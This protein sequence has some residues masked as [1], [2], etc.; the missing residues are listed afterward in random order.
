MPTRNSPTGGVSVTPRPLF[1]YRRQFL[2]TDDEL[3][4]GRLL[5]CP[6][7]ASPFGAQVR[8]RGGEVVSVDPTY[9]RSVDEIRRMV[10]HNLEATPAWISTKGDAID[11]SD[12]GSMNALLRAFEPAG[13]LFLTDFAAH[14][15]HYVAGT[16]PDLPLPDDH[17]R[18]ALSSFLLFAYADVFDVD[19]HVAALRE[20]S[21]VAAEVRVFPLVDSDAVPYPHLDDVRAALGEHGVRTELRP[22][23][24]TYSVGADHALVCTRS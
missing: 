23:T 3:V 14:P 6:A 13:D 8:A 18:I 16:L 5:D 10:E 17:A 22:T 12:L 15:E 1:D 7:G 9:S 4:G 11:W 19:D 2:L 20:L 21:R 24:A